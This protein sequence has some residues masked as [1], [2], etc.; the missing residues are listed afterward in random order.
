MS[1]CSCQQWLQSASDINVPSCSADNK[2]TAKFLIRCFHRVH[3][4]Y[5]DLVPSVPSGTLVDDS[6]PVGTIADMQQSSCRS[7]L[8]PSFQ[9]VLPCPLWSFDFPPASSGL[10][11]YSLVGGSCRMCPLKRLLHAAPF[12]QIASLLY[13]WWCDHAIKCPGSS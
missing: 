9:R 4:T 3:H 13:R 7:S 6:S 2:R 8:C 1:A 12:A 10:T 5:L 11:S